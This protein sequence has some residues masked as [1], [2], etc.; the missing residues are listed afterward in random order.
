M[1]PVILTFYVEV[2]NRRPLCQDLLLTVMMTLRG[3][4][5]RSNEK[6]KLIL[7]DE[8]RYTSRKG[9]LVTER[10][11]YVGFKML[12]FSWLYTVRC[13]IVLILNLRWKKKK[14]LNFKP[15]SWEFVTIQFYRPI[16]GLVRVAVN[17]LMSQGNDFHSDSNTFEYNAVLEKELF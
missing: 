11:K 15:F 14:M 12:F 10:G 1:W 5:F 6:I 7:T 8:K 2:I 16:I 4:F 13:T 9:H 17:W 3:F